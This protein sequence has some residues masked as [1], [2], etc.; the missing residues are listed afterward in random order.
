MLRK[1]MF[2]LEYFVNEE[3]CLIRSMIDLLLGCFSAALRV[4]LVIRFCVLLYDVLFTEIV[5][6]CPFEFLDAALFL[7]I[8]S[9]PPIPL[10]AL[11]ISF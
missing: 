6:F 1:S 5:N 11:S 4:L 2:L 9:S 7:K 8:T 3:S 10:Y